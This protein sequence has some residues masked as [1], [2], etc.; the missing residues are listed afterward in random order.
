[1]L[2][3]C[4]IVDRADPWLRLHY[5]LALS[6][7]GLDLRRVER[8]SAPAGAKPTTIGSCAL[9]QETDR[10]SRPDTINQPA[11]PVIRVIFLPEIVQ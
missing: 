8:A 9:P 3:T 2:D 11:S 6:V 5:L 7:P 1:V 4:E 10:H